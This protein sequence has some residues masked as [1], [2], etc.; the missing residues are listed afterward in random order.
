MS[1]YDDT[2]YKKQSFWPYI[3]I[4]LISAIIGGLIIA[5]FLPGVDSMSNN[6]INTENNKVVQTSSQNTTVE[7]I[8]LMEKESAVIKVAESL[9]PAV[10]GISNRKAPAQGFSGF[11]HP[12]IEGQGTVEQ[13]TGSGV[14]IDEAGYI[15]TNNHVVQGAS[16]IMVTLADGREVSGKIVGT[17]IQTDL[18]VVKIEEKNLTVASLGNSDN[19]KVG[20]LAIAIGNPLG[21]EFAGTVTTGIISALNRT[22]TM[23]EQEYKL[24][25]TDAAINPGNSGGALVDAAGQLIGIN[26][27]KIQGQEIEGINF[28]IP[29]S[30]AKPIIDDLIKHG[31]VIRPWLGVVFRGETVTEDI[32]K[33][34]DM[35][36]NFGVVIEVSPNGPA[37]SSGL[38]NS[39]IIYKIEDREIKEFKDLR[40]ALE[41][42]NPGDSIKVSVLRGKEKQTISVKLGDMPTE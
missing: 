26:S 15:V 33:Q 23:G 31:K 37:S 41:G 21:Q 20:Q 22:I 13:G 11:N 39:D 32:A 28:A 25:Q 19:L 1:V 30:I 17:D 29:I 3:V 16:E 10:V 42:K 14:I 40:M 7:P 9:G 24:I 34:Y 38:Q 8:P 6:G 18:A 5:F 2:N 35:P 36:I 12:S 4:S 27:A